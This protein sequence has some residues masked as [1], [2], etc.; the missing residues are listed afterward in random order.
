MRAEYVIYCSGS[1]CNALGWG[2][3]LK[4]YGANGSVS[5]EAFCHTACASSFANAITVRP[6]RPDLG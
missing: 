5:A 6:L 2:S 1:S 3:R 4:T